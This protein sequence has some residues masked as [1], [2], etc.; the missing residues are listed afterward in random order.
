MAIADWLPYPLP[1]YINI[2]F[3]L[4]MTGHLRIGLLAAYTIL[5]VNDPIMGAHEISKSSNFR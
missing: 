2:G 3:G 5:I 1:L 4:S